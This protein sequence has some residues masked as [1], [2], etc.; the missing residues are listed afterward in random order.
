MVLITLQ[1]AVV[2]PIWKISPIPFPRWYQGVLVALGAGMM[3]SVLF[4]KAKSWQLL[5]LSGLLA[6][7]LELTRPGPDQ[8]GL[9]FDAP[10]GLVLGFSGGSQTFWVNYPILPWFEVV[11]LGMAFGRWYLEDQGQAACR[12]LLFGTGMLLL[13]VPLRALDGFG[14]IR[15]RPGDSWIDFLNVVKYPP[16]LTFTLLTL[17]V[18]FLLLFSLQFARGWLNWLAERLAV[19]GR[20]P[21]VLYLAHLLLYALL[22]RLLTPEGSSYAVMYLL[23][24]VG[25]LGLYPLA[26]VYP[27]LKRRPGL[28]AVLRY[29]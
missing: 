11:L 21:L 27:R 2:N 28:G 12:A 18:N 9:L 6:L 15:P 25:L 26:L 8:W 16:S 14:N 17:G 4:L 23:W 7:G 1:F 22:G 19:Y 29:L 20:A 24:L 3:L 10:L 13:F 5:A